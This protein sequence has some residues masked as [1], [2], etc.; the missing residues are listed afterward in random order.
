MYWSGAGAL[1]LAAGEHRL[2][3]DAATRAIG[4]ALGGGLPLAHEVVRLS[5]PDAVDAAIAI[6]DL[7]AADRLLGLFADRPLG[8]VPPFLRAQV[9]RAKALVARARGEDGHVAE[10]LLAA[11]T[12]FRGLG[13]PY[14]T[15]RVQ[16]E[17]AEWLAAEHRLDESA[18]LAGDA[19]AAFDALGAAPMLSRA[20]ALLEPAARRSHVGEESATRS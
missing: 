11:E 2:A 3:L 10:N 15:A 19:A 9:T 14:W 8:E 16:L 13:Y 4:D 5:L 6:G 18:L 12:T 7:E 20:R 17:R 1:A